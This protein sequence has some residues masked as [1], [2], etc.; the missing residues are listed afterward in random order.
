MLS[1][2]AS[3]VPSYILWVFP[4][5]RVLDLFEKVGLKPP[6]SQQREK[7]E[8][9]AFPIFDQNPIDGM[10]VPRERVKFFIDHKLS[11]EPVRQNFKGAKEFLFHPELLNR[12]ENFVRFWI[13]LHL[14]K[15][16]FVHNHLNDVAL[17][18]VLTSVATMSVVRH[19]LGL[20]FFLSGISYFMLTSLA[21]RYIVEPS[22][23]K[24]DDWC[25][26]IAT[27]EE[28]K[29]GSKFFAAEKEFKTLPVSLLESLSKPFTNAS[30]RYEKCIQTLN[31]RGIEYCPTRAEIIPYEKYL[32]WT[33]LRH[34]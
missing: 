15:L 16:Q 19:L 10:S 18:T 25:M 34:A 30:A 8:S 5:M 31:E 1:T 20:N 4:A 29:E 12:D 26:E 11:K 6:S 23:K 2:I 21:E 32:N 28:L 3:D 13:K 22:I 14:R 9:F 27:D 7:I 33:I 17:P 24:A